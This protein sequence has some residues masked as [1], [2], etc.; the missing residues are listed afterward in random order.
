MIMISISLN[1]QFIERY[2]EEGDLSWSEFKRVDTS[3]IKTASYFTYYLD[4]Y[5]AFEKR[6][7]TTFYFFKAENFTDRNALT[8]ADQFAD[9]T[10]L[11]YHQLLFDISELAKRRM[12][13]SFFSQG[14]ILIN[15]NTLLDEAYDAAEEDIAQMNEDTNFGLEIS[16]LKEWRDSI[17]DLIQKTGDGYIPSYALK[18][19]GFG[20]HIGL[21]GTIHNGGIKDYVK[22]P[23]F[24]KLG[25]NAHFKKIFTGLDFTFGNG[26]ATRDTEGRLEWKVDDNVRQYNIMANAGYVMNSGRIQF[27]PYIGGGMS[28]YQ[29]YFVDDFEESFTEGRVILAPQIGA[30]LDFFFYKR[31]NFN[32]IY[33]AYYNTTPD[34]AVESHGIRLNFSFTPVSFSGPLN[35]SGNIYQIS[36][37]YV[38]H[39]R[40]MTVK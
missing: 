12:Q 16:G 26:K 11:A 8:V 34:R 25:V 7:D 6:K 2:W 39:N 9:S 27:I 10:F 20:A 23:V 29:Y 5:L 38:F 1:A 17:T 15:A 36:A 19:N 4:Y 22:S 31:A 33:H 3:E 40:N 28:G 21:G 18:N 14:K 35:A 32:R 37:N 30:Y 13:K 24:F